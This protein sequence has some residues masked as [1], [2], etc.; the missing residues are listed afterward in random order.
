MA[1][2]T[3]SYSTQPDLY[4]P[5]TEAK[6]SRPKPKFLGRVV[7]GGAVA[8]GFL[9]L[10]VNF[11]KDSVQDGVNHELAAEIVNASPNAVQAVESG[12]LGQGFEVIRSPASG[13]I[14]YVASAIGG[15]NTGGAP[16]LQTALSAQS[17]AGVID[18]GQELAVPVN[19]VDPQLQQKLEAN[20]Q[21]V[22]P[23][24]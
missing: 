12:K 5:R 20:H 3:T 19:F 15:E 1:S 4:R 9:Y 10:G 6:P 8:A 24:P 23:K 16:N 13:Y 21:V 18:R 2:R 7:L 22:Y 14:G 11:V 17:P